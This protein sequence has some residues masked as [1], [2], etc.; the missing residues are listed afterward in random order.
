MRRDRR[1]RRIASLLAV[2]LALAAGGTARAASLLD[3]PAAVDAAPSGPQPVYLDLWVNDVKRDVVLAELE[4]GDAWVPVKD[5]LRAGLHD[6]G[7]VRRAS[8]GRELVSLR[9]LAPGLRWRLDDAALA[10]RVVASPALLGRVQLDLSPVRRPEKAFEAPVPSAFLNWSAR[11]DTD[12]G[13]SGFAEAGASTGHGDLLFSSGSVDRDGR[14]VRGLTTFTL[15]RPARMLRLDAGDVVSSP[16]GLGGGG[17]LLGLGLARDFSLDPY[18][19][20]SPLPSM[21]GFAANPS[22]LEVWVNGALVRRQPLP[23]GAYDVWNLPLTA[24]ANDVQLVVRDAFG[25][26]ESVARTEYLGAGLLAPGVHDFAVTAGLRR[27]RLDRSA[28]YGSALLVARER[29]GITDRL[30]AGAR[31]EAGRDLASGGGSLSLGSPLGD[32]DL[33]AAASGSG[34]R[35]GG[36]AY[37]AWRLWTRIATAAAYVR[38]LSRDYANGALD[39]GDD[40]ALVRA[41]VL[42]SVPVLRRAT[43]AAEWTVALDRDRGRETR[44]ALRTSIGLGRGFVLFASVARTTSSVA[45]PGWEGG[46]TLALPL[47]DASAELSADAR[48][49]GD[50]TVS[51]SV[52]RST[53]VG[54]GLGYRLR[55]GADRDAAF[56][57]AFAEGHARFGQAEL[58]YDQVGE[59][60][61]GT[62]GAA[63]GIVALQDRVFLARPV[64]QSFAL[65][66]VGVPG[67][68]TTLENQPMGRTD[69]NGEILFPSMAPFRAS[70]IGIVDT[71]VPLDRRVRERELLL[72][73]PRRAGAVARFGIDEYRAVTG[74][75]HLF[76]ARGLTVPARGDLVVRGGRILVLSSPIDD[77]GAFWIEGLP[78]GNHDAEIRWHGETCGF[79]LSIPTGVAGV[80]DLGDLGCEEK[81]APAPAAEP[82]PTSTPTRA[83]APAPTDALERLRRVLPPTLPAPAPVR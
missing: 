17:V 75:L 13:R 31:L 56:A 15:D 71:D 67:V 43:A 27:E 82:T 6:L 28:D 8:A 44:T 10:L 76:G 4:P 62:A 5:L 40:R 65:V 79:T 74:R 60:A 11:A 77:D 24:G 1:H 73:P 54:E 26:T 46:L 29:A 64:D 58:W 83:A 14:V 30:T 22:T 52:Q 2:A 37:G 35:A 51:A 38:C 20:Q 25:R 47:G 12:G 53:P 36:A 78:P 39:P 70:R 66:Q 23:P 81:P 32:L 72:V 33:E 9:S 50:D 18:F 42:A 21:T 34:G 41:G 16:S 80:V 61:V 48:G 68:R 63:G 3:D 19:V 7:G 49:A 55:A 57:H 45:P 69:A 59:Q